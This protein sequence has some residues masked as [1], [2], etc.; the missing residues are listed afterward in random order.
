LSL[1]NWYRSKPIWIAGL[2]ADEKLRQSG[3]FGSVALEFRF[4]DLL[5]ESGLTRPALGGLDLHRLAQRILAK[6]DDVIVWILGY[7]SA[8]DQVETLSVEC[9]RRNAAAML[10]A[11]AAF[12]SLVPMLTA[13]EFSKPKV[14]RV[15]PDPIYDRLPRDHGGRRLRL[16]FSPRIRS[17]TELRRVRR[18]VA[19]LSTAGR[20]SRVISSARSSRSASSFCTHGGHE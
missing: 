16:I 11:L 3:H 12:L 15:R 13:G 7:A 18:E 20:S 8:R 17:D 2:A 4:D 10:E 19:H 9:E 5:L 1:S 6:S 14:R